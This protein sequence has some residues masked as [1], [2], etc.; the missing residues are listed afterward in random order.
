MIRIITDTASDITLSQAKA[1]GIDIV[2]MRVQFGDSPYNQLQDEDF[3]AFYTLLEN[4]KALPTTSQPSPADFLEL[5]EDAQEKKQ[6]V[7]VITISSGLSG[8]LQAATIA[9]DMCDY[10]EI[11]IIDSKQ[12]AMGQRLLVEYAVQLRA[13]GN[14]AAEIAVL[15]REA[16]SRVVLYAALDTLKY[17]R[18][19]GR[20]PKSAELLGTVLSIKPIIGLDTEGKVCM[21]GKAR[22]LAGAV[23]NLIKLMDERNDIDDTM[24]V[25]FGYTLQETPSRNFMKVATA[26]YHLKNAQFYPVGATIGTHIGPGAMAVAYLCKSANS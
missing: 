3:S 13:Q 20:I 2:A 6:S 10:D 7:V 23:T 14:S 8:T 21:R 22:G 24:P 19:G 17:L 5:Y 26:R 4:A 25:Y 12:A 9:K 11:Y 18:K 15:V 1:L 16:S